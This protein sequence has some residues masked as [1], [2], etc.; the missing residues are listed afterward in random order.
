MS[1]KHQ[2]YSNAPSNRGTR[3]N[4]CLEVTPEQFKAVDDA[5][6]QRD[7][8][9]GALIRDLINVYLIGTEVKNK[10]PTSAKAL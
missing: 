6:R 7:I 8:S 9:R 1:F 3:P 4:I 2:R 5:A 10:P